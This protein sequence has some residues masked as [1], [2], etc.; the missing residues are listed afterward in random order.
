MPEDFWGRITHNAGYKL[1]SALLAC[2]IWLYV[3]GDEVADAKLKARL[4]WVL[5]TGLT[6]VEQLPLERDERLFGVLKQA[7]KRFIVLLHLPLVQTVSVR[8]RQAWGAERLLHRMCTHTCV[9]LLCV[10]SRDSK[11][12]RE[13]AV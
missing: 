3:Q 7:I 1:L 4:V 2:S 10:V 12:H 9:V 13:P 5:P 6:T 11:Q 8:V